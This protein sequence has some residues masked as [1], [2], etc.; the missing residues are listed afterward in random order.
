MTYTTNQSQNWDYGKRRFDK[1]PPGFSSTTELES[2]IS[3][4][5]TV[6]DGVWVPVGRGVIQTGIVAGIRQFRLP[7]SNN[8]AANFAGVLLWEMT[9]FRMPAQPMYTHG[10]DDMI[11]VKKAGGVVVETCS[12]IPA[13]SKVFCVHTAATGEAVGQFKATQGTNSFEIKFAKW[14]EITTAP[15]SCE[16]ELFTLTN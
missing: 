12:A 1:L 8:D 9:N 4:V 14:T 2:I 5:L 7:N 13:N 16:L 10:K 6:A 15:G 3:G 11:D